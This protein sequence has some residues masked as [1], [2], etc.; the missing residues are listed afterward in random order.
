MSQMPKGSHRERMR[1]R[2]MGKR[3]ERGGG[4]E[5]RKKGV[6]KKAVNQMLHAYESMR[7]TL[8]SNPRERGFHP[9]SGG[10]NSRR[11]VRSYKNL[12]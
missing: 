5:T 6:L 8:T 12:L 4:E 3:T 9:N 11:G 1:T 2:G 10:G 7:N